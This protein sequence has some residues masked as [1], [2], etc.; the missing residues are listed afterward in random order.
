MA[1][2]TIKSIQLP[3]GDN[4]TI[5]IPES[6]V[7]NLTTDL[8]TKAPL[9]S[10]D[11]TGTPTAPTAA[12]GTDTTQIATTAFVAAAVAS[13]SSSASIEKITNTEI[14]AMIEQVWSINGLAS[15]S[16]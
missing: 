3:N 16:F 13:A 11:L 9:A 5:T 4:C 6:Q 14:D 1:N 7:V 15:A 10:P 2:Y 12:A 8:A